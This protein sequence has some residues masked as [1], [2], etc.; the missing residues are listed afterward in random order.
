MEKLFLR[1]DRRVF[2]ATYVLLTV[3][4]AG[5]VV[6]VVA[7]GDTCTGDAGAAAAWVGAATAGCVCGTVGMQGVWQ[8]RGGG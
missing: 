6:L 8:G 4:S 3:K 1:I 2:T 7:G 5:V